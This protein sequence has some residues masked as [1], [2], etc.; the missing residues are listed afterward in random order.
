[1]LTNEII[2]AARAPP[3]SAHPDTPR[4]PGTPRTEA[5]SSG[6]GIQRTPHD[7]VVSSAN[8][9]AGEAGTAVS[10]TFHN[11]VKHKQTTGSQED[12]ELEEL[13]TLFSSLK[14]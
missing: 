14:I 12:E 13:G 6:K 11:V 1:M 2:K 8:D 7:K 10:N 4:P 3:S 9:E 5:E